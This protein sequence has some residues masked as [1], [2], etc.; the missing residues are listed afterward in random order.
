MRIMGIDPGLD[1]GIAIY[2]GGPLITKI[3]PTLGTGKRT[4]DAGNLADWLREQQ[5]Q[6]DIDTTFLEL[7]GAMPGQGVTSMFTFGE[8]Y[9]VIKGVLAVLRIPYTLVSPRKWQTAVGVKSTKDDTKGA[10]MVRAVQLFPGHNFLATA[11]SKKPHQ[12]MVDAALLAYFG[13]FHMRGAA[14]LPVAVSAAAPTEAA[15]PKGADQS[16]LAEW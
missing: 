4:L 2:S 12:G 11:R 6:G 9:G 13:Y 16:K 8:G 3:M 5:R 7:V 14:D 1:G 10:A 15:A